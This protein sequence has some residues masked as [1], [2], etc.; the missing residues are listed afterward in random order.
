[1]T[2]I[3]H[4]GTSKIIVGPPSR[5]AILALKIFENKSIISFQAWFLIETFKKY[6]KIK[7]VKLSIYFRSSS[8]GS[9]K[10]YI[11]FEFIIIQS[12]C[13]I[14]NGSNSIKSSQIHKI[15]VFRGQKRFALSQTLLNIKSQFSSR[16][17]K[18]IP[19]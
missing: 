18:K 2:M 1:M 8:W 19:L 14:K 6:F 13:T 17:L 7:F 12:F 4:G 10:I 15:Q 11:D 9:A 5:F 16:S 3:N